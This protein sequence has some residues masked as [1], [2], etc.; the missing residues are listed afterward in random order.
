[1]GIRDTI[2]RL[3]H[4]R[5]HHQSTRKRDEQ[6]RNIHR[7]VDRRY[8]QKKRKGRMFHQDKPRPTK[9]KGSA[10]NTALG[11]LNQCAPSPTKQR[12]RGSHSPIDAEAR[13]RAS[14]RLRYEASEKKK[15]LREQEKRKPNTFGGIIYGD[16]KNADSGYSMFGNRP[17]ARRNARRSDEDFFSN[18]WKI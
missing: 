15:I 11:I 18:M 1:M 13:R 8:E 2:D 17:K 14:K 16:T 3:R 4:S 5:V 9:K 12:R 10:M 6:E 7:E